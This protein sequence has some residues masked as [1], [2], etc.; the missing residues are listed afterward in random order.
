M[1]NKSTLSL[2]SDG[3]RSTTALTTQDDPNNA[4]YA[5][6]LE[7][8]SD[9]CDPIQQAL[10]AEQEENRRLREESQQ[11][12]EQNSVLINRLKNLGGST[13]LSPE[14]SELLVPEISRELLDNLVRENLRIKRELQNKSSSTHLTSQ[15]GWFY[16][17]CFLT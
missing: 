5:G 17:I 15:V 9:R 1:R 16:L 11:V 4:L 10:L 14:D 7:E 13:A 12:R 8:D 2:T 3:V 6:D